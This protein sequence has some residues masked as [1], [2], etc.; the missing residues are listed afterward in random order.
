MRHAT[1]VVQ[2]ERELFLCFGNDSW[3]Q[4]GK[5]QINLPLFAEDSQKQEIRGRENFSQWV[6]DG[7][8]EQ[9]KSLSDDEVHSFSES[10]TSYAAMML[11]SY[12]LVGLI[13]K[14]LPPYFMESIEDYCR[15]AKL[16][17][18]FDIKPWVEV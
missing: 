4:Y 9:E 1:T 15:R 11:V 7:V 8:N 10:S 2:D 18:G 6:Y 12:Y 17:S 16:Q 5:N 13:Q 14:S 3:I